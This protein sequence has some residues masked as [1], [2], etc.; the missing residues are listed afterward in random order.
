MNVNPGSKTMADKKWSGPP[1][2]NTP[3]PQMIKQLRGLTK[4]GIDILNSAQF[5]FIYIYISLF[6]D[7]HAGIRRLNLHF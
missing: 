6:Q 1:N 2:S 4:S 5:Y 7:A 3:A